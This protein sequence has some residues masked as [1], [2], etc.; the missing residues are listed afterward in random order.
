[1][2]SL[3][4]HCNVSWQDVVV[5]TLHMDRPFTIFY[6]AIHSVNTVDSAPE[7]SHGVMA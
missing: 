7:D 1:M 6:L 3:T 5:D 2:T 4:G